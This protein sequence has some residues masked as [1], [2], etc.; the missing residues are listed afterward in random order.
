MDEQQRVE[1]ARAIVG[2][3]VDSDVLPDRVR[4]VRVLGGDWQREPGVGDRVLGVCGPDST[5][6]GTGEASR[7]SHWFC[8]HSTAVIAAVVTV[9]WA[10]V[11]GTVSK[12]L[13]WW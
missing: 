10:F 1:M 12:L 13:G 9:Q 4:V 2:G 5:V 11:A 6:G 8:S 3:G 7:V